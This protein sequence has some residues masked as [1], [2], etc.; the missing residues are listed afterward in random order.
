MVKEGSQPSSRGRGFD[1]TLQQITC[2]DDGTTGRDDLCGPG[3]LLNKSASCL[4]VVRPASPRFCQLEI[5]FRR[6]S[7][8]N[9]TGCA[10][11]RLEIVD[12]D[13]LCRE[14]AGSRRYQWKDNELRM[15]FV[16]NG[17][18]VSH[19]FKIY[20]TQIPCHED[21]RTLKISKS[22]SSNE[23]NY[24]H[25]ELNRI[26]SL[27]STAMA[28]L[29]DLQNPRLCFGKIYSDKVFII[30][31]PEIPNDTRRNGECV[32]VIQQH[33]SDV[34]RLRFMLKY[35]CVGEEHNHTR[36]DGGYLE[37]DGRQ[38]CGCQ[39]GRA[40]TSEFGLAVN[41]GQKI[42]K[43][44]PGKLHIPA[45]RGF[46]IEVVQETCFVIENR[47]EINLDHHAAAWP[48]TLSQ[49]VRH[50]PLVI[51][52]S[53]QQNSEGSGSTNE[54]SQGSRHEESSEGSRVRRS[55]YA[56]G[57]WKCNL[58]TWFRQLGEGFGKTCPSPQAP[59]CRVTNEVEG[60]LQSPNYP[61]PY[62]ANL[63]C[64]YRIARRA[65]YCRLQL[66]MLDF[67]LQLSAGC[68]EDYLVLGDRGRYCG[69]S[70]AA[71]TSYL[72]LS[73]RGHADVLFVTD[74]DGAGRGFR[75]AFR[76]LPC[77]A[78]GPTTPGTATTRPPSYP[79]GDLVR[80]RSFRL[81]SARYN[82][83]LAVCTFTVLRAGQ[84]SMER[85]NLTCGQESLQI[86]SQFYCGVLTGNYV[87]AKFSGDEVQ[88]VYRKSTVDSPGEFVIQG[89]QVADCELTLLSAALQSSSPGRLEL[90]V[91]RL[92]QQLEAREHRAELHERL[93]RRVRPDWKLPA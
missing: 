53:S 15:L 62:P 63:R 18:T 70:L 84:I 45:V 59:R 6:F 87:S 39:T 47:N 1:L 92:A 72:D 16:T 74:S 76:Q 80:G 42:L 12:Q 31:S 19:D 33:N 58:K 85:F 78:W 36:C 71:T 32:I 51:S 56:N 88:I 20:V 35:F 52:D 10:K 9:S 83:A 93:P 57:F 73:A 44:V 23:Q 21:D 91:H 89:Q 26:S 86:G 69:A 54:H 38:I 34:C 5:T 3:V 37:V 61:G 30:T 41:E 17:E 81:A 49:L 64:C 50:R 24:T 67:S 75:A 11:P 28:L 48:K 22:S 82:L 46:V 68:G 13:V 77:S 2:A 40:V 29:S 66:T 60:I 14:V 90:A 79:C 8:D 65:G 25:Y 43:Y 55:P 4:Y 7:L 27:Q